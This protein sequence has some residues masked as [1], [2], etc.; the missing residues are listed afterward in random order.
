MTAITK[1]ANEVQRDSPDS[2]EAGA[3]CLTNGAAA[4]A[5]DK[6][7][8][9]GSAASAAKEGPLWDV[10]GIG[11]WYSPCLAACGGFGVNKSLSHSLW[12]KAPHTG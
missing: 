11:R 4:S 7:S 6:G 3:E 10:L 2:R 9:G 12:S 1:A 5:S 8:A